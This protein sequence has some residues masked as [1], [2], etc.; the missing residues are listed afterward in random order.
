MEAVLQMSVRELAEKT[1]V[2]TAS[3]IRF[4]QKMGCDGFVE[5]KT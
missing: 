4:C 2:S 1:Y 5:F 3:I